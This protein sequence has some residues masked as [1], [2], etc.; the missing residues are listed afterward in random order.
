M[1]NPLLDRVSPAE[2]A[3]R[4]QVFDLKGSVGDFDRLVGIVESELE[5]EPGAGPAGDWRKA[6]VE[7]GLSFAWLDTNRKLPSVTGSVSTRLAVVCQRCLEVFEMPLET[8]VRVVFT[9]AGSGDRDLR[10]FDAWE[11]E[12]D[13]LRI[14]DIV[15]EALVMALPLAPAHESLDDCG[16]LA[17]KITTNTP[18]KTRPFADLRAQME[19]ANK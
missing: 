16:P 5:A 2:L 10:D 1:A 14:K 15:E 12:N 18:E 13:T 6:V 8:D 3:D 11:M 19:K 9:D 7:T 4:S 17:T